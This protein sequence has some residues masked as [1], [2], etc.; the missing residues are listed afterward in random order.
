MSSSSIVWK[1]LPAASLQQDGL[2]LQGWDRLNAARGDL[3]FLA[4]D[5]IVSALKAFGDG[6]ERLLVARD[7][8]DVLAMFLLAPQGRFRWQTFQPSQLPLGA[9]VAAAHVRLPEIARSLLRGPLGLCL[10]LSITQIDPN[11]AR[12]SDD[13]SDNESSDYIDTA[14]VEIEGT[15]DEYWSARGK[16]LRQNMRKQRAKLQ[17]DGV[18]LTMQVL[19]HHADMAPAI[20]RYGSLESVGWKAEKG[21]AIHPD[22]AQGHFYVELLEHASRRGEAVVYQYLFDERV[23]AMNLCLQR[24]GTLVVLKTTYDESIK[25]FSPAFLLRENELQEIYR[26]GQVRRIEYFGRLMDWHTKLTDRKRGL[27]HLTQYRWPVL[28]KLAHVRRGNSKAFAA[29]TS[30]SSSAAT[31]V[32]TS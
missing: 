25:S 7:G 13:T 10:V 29:T 1:N 27:Y 14:W 6:S 3:V 24:N 8:D 5:A 28:K 2:L 21:T 31:N 22:N 15:F 32:A 26:E 19:R 18:N 30:D 4:G 11:I 12:R 20:A 9:W 16:N 23:V 17:A